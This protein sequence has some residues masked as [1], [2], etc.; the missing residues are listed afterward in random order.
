MTV[1][2][3]GVAV[4]LLLPV[5]YRWLRLPEPPPPAGPYDWRR[6]TGLLDVW[7]RD[8]EGELVAVFPAGWAAEGGA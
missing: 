7:A 8:D 5:V 2:L 1:F 3:V 4:G 6:D